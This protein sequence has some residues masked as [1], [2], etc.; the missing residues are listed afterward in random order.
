MPATR[1][2]RGHRHVLPL[3]ALAAS[4]QAREGRVNAVDDDARGGLLS[5][6]AR[7]GLA[8]NER[9]GADA[10]VHEGRQHLREHRRLEREDVVEGARAHRRVELPQYPHAAARAPCEEHAVRQVKQAHAQRA[11]HMDQQ[12]RRGERAHGAREPEQGHLGVLR[13][14]LVLV[15]LNAEEALDVA[16]RHLAVERPPP[17]IQRLGSVRLAHCLGHELL[18]SRRRRRERAPLVVAPSFALLALP[19]ASLAVAPPLGRAVDEQAVQLYARVDGNLGLLRTPLATSVAV[20]HVLE[21]LEPQRVVYTHGSPIAGAGAVRALGPRARLG[22]PQLGEVRLK[23]QVEVRVVVAIRH[24]VLIESP[25]VQ[26]V[27]PAHEHDAIEMQLILSACL[28][29]A[30]C[31]ESVGRV[32]VTRHQARARDGVAVQLEHATGTHVVD[33]KVESVA[34]H[35]SL[36]RGDSDYANAGVKPPA[37]GVLLGERFLYALLARPVNYD[38]FPH[39]LQREP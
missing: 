23:P 6:G 3:S 29:P 26:V 5:A 2:D 21:L 36:L 18:Q 19:S 22:A 8:V 37:L 32:R 11:A 17:R 27:L 34:Q 10:A 35:P 4:A 14:A 1:H 15:P 24:D 28:L 16:A 25:D 38:H 33:A 12:H 7:V 20:L 13:N 39:T 31:V 30:A 9:A